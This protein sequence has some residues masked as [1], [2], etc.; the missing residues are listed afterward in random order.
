MK[1]GLTAQFPASEPQDYFCGVYMALEPF[2]GE[3]VTKNIFV[4]R[5]ADA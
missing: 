2:S 1:M 5:L 4:N 3:T